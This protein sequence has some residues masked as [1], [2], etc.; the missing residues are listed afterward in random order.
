MLHLFSIIL[1]VRVIQSL[2]CIPIFFPLHFLFFLTRFFGLPLY[3]FL[4]FFIHIFSDFIFSSL[5]LLFYPI[6]KSIFWCKFVP[7][8]NDFPNLIKRD[9]TICIIQSSNISCLCWKA[10]SSMHDV[11]IAQMKLCLYNFTSMFIYELPLLILFAFW[12]RTNSEIRN[13]FFLIH[14]FPNFLIIFKLR[15]FK[16]SYSMKVHK[17]FIN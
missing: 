4:I 16:C 1:N 10:P 15:R 8:D 6:K 17:L 3:L 11:Y 5:F 9:A 13:V 2:L 14:L 7:D 12:S